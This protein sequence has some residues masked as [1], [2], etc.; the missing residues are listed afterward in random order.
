MAILLT[1][2][3]GFIGS[4]T[5]L[6]LVKNNNDV[7]VIDSLTNSSVRSIYKVKEILSSLNFDKSKIKF[8][9]CDITNEKNLRRIFKNQE[10]NNNPINSVIHFAGLKSIKES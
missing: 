10:K 1:G 6:E 3:A 2:G 9:K 4:H 8:L 7:V 5:I